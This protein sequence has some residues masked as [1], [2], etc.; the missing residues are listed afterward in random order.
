MQSAHAAVRANQR[1]VGFAEGEEETSIRAAISFSQSGLGTP[2]LIGREDQ[3][4]ATIK[5]LGLT[6]ANNIEIQNA[7]ISR[8]NKH[9]TEYLYKRMQR[10]GYLYRDCKRLVNQD[11]NVFSACM[12]VHGDIDAIITGLSRSYSVSH[13]NIRLAIDPM[14]GAEVFGMSMVT[15]RGQTVFIADT[16]INERPSGEQLAQIASQCAAEAIAHGHEPRVAFLSHATFGNPPG[17]LATQVRGAVA[18]LDAG[19]ADFEYDGE[20]SPD[21]ALDM[22]LRSVF[23]FCRLTGPAN[24]L[25][26]PGLHAAAIS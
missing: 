9:F 19:D 13:D 10:D 1:R 4:K 23:P 5:R 24:I 25:I 3:I 11:R 6:G 22:K 14:P 16:T 26:M 15:S 20:M 18:I 21:V 2:V 7:A 12:L 8:G 17:A